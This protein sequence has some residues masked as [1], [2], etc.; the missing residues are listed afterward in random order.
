MAMKSL[1]LFSVVV[2]IAFATSCVPHSYFITGHTPDYGQLIIGHGTSDQITSTFSFSWDPDGTTCS[3]NGSNAGAPGDAWLNVVN[4]P[5]MGRTNFSIMYDKYWAEADSVWHGR[6]TFPDGTAFTWVEANSKAEVDKYLA[7]FRE[8]AESRRRPSP[9]SVAVAAPSPPAAKPKRAGFPSST[10]EF[11]YAKAVQ[12]PDDIAVIIGNADYSKQG[13]D[14]PDVIPAHADASAFKGY[15]IQAQGILEGNIINLRDA[16]AAQMARV[17][18]TPSDHR[19][20]LFDWVRPGESRVWVYYAGHG[21]PAGREGT[22]YLVPA[23]ADGSRIQLNGYALATLYRNLGRLP[24][25]SVTI[26]L[27]ACF[28]GAS[29]EG[30][31]INSAS[32][33]YARPKE[34]TVP[35]GVTVIA[36]GA[37]DQ[38]A[39]W[40]KDK[41]HGLFTRYFLTGMAGAADQA[42]HGNGDGE[43]SYSELERYLRRTLTYFARRHY[44][45][46]QKA[47]IVIGK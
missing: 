44:G 2:S 39:S 7:R 46:D 42:P 13:K 30:S 6:G 4:C 40:D 15:L 8:K 33:I 38:I 47:Q 27:E 1:K 32:G 29:Q 22:S 26:V 37:P 21:A 43:V 28:S 23:D 16:T 10:L 11:T 45:R 9:A 5:G 18:G 12:R 20:Q 24:A 34:T 25:R 17:F 14:I 36:A 3:G 31:V 19:G 41:S 35:A